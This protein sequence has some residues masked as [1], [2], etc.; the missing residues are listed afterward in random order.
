MA[1]KLVE[2]EV[3][4]LYR[5]FHFLQSFDRNYRFIKSS[6][7]LSGNTSKIILE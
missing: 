6:Y 7:F 3:L 1:K 4:I 2:D 5:P